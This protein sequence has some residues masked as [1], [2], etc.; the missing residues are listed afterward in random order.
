MIKKGVI[1]KEFVIFLFSDLRG[2]SN[3]GGSQQHAINTLWGVTL[4][5]K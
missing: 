5:S 1:K 2:R 4:A 3:L